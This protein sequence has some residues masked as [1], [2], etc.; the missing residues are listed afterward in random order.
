MFK[1][2]F[3]MLTD[4]IPA[5]RFQVEGVIYQQVVIEIVLG[6]KKCQNYFTITSYHELVRYLINIEKDNEGDINIEVKDADYALK[7]DFYA[8]SI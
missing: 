2:D 1:F 3:P 6:D 4:N 7:A 8:Q 5:E